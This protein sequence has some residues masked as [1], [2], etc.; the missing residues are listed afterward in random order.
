MI[1]GV[2]RDL[3]A[4][5]QGNLLDELSFTVQGEY[6]V[7]VIEVHAEG[8]TS[9]RVQLRA[10]LPA[11]SSLTFASLVEG[12]LPPET[13]TAAYL[14]EREAATTSIWTPSARG[15]TLRI[16]VQI[17]LEASL[18]GS[19]L[20]LDQVAQ[21]F[22]GAMQGMNPQAENRLAGVQSTKTR[23][24]L[25]RLDCPRNYVPAVCLAP[26]ATRAQLSMAG[27]I[28]LMVFEKAGRSGICSGTLLNGAANR[29]Q[30]LTA[31]HCIA[32]G[33]VAS[34]LETHHY[35]LNTQCST[36]RFVPDAGYFRNVRGARLLETLRSADQTLLELRDPTVDY[37]VTLA[38]W[39]ADPADARP[40]KSLFG[41]HHPKGT[42]MAGSRGTAT[43]YGPSIAGG[44]RV[45]NALYVHDALG[46]T[47][48]GSSGSGLFAAEGEPYLVGVLFAGPVDSRG[49]TLCNGRSQYGAF[50]DFW[51][52]AVAHLDPGTPPASDTWKDIALI[53]WVLPA[54]VRSQQ[55]V[56]RFVN[57]SD[58][59]ARVRVWSKRDDRR[60]AVVACTFTV[61][62]L[63]AA[64]LT[65]NDLADG[66]RSK[67]CRGVGGASVSSGLLVQSDT[68]SLVVRSYGRAFG[69][70]A[71]FLAPLDGAAEGFES[72]GVWTYYLPL[73]NP[74]TD[75]TAQARVRLTNTDRRRSVR[76]VYFWGHDSY[77]RGTGTTLRLARA[78]LPL[79]T[80]T[81]SALDLERGKRGVLAGA[82]FGSPRGQWAAFVVASG[83]V[84][85]SAYVVGRTLSA[86]VSR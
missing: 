35:F 10:S 71:G 28:V 44:Q 80:V 16:T 9:V 59:P 34:S 82:P 27:A 22:T 46:Q 72:K 2:H 78:L 60:R 53:P 70:N 62:A 83:P 68:P 77:G 17:P 75:S 85:V 43:H 39:S 58:A 73:L 54:N 84:H 4:G 30:L 48:G 15:E 50:A 33:A 79:Q 13:W 3:P 63:A 36:S 40:G 66:A 41:L 61:R 14:E 81:L 6:R 23:A 31:H 65:A 37:P 8:A 25:S 5:Y 42:P 69:T 67:G 57:S 21:R 51:R 47:E 29:L 32:T 20:L 12:A 56:L 1:I 76:S 24:N 86:N 55:S 74:G 45:P 64:H 18:D 52:V 26:Y 11:G 49:R 7:G 19:Y 38:G